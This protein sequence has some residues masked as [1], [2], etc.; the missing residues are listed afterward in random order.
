MPSS[1]RPPERRSSEAHS[2]AVTAYN[3]AG[4]ESAYSNIVTIPAA[5]LAPAIDDAA[6]DVRAHLLSELRGNPSRLVDDAVDLGLRHRC[7]V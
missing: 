7:F 2:F 1:R 3:T 4:M 5:P 6:R